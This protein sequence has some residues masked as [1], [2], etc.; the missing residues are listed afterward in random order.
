MRK[1]WVYKITSP[2]GRVY[3]GSTVNLKVRMSAYKNLKCIEQPKLYRSLVKHG[4]EKHTV[5]IICECTSLNRLEKESFFGHLYNVLSNDNLN[6]CLPK[7]NENP[8]CYNEKE[9]Q[10]RKVFMIGR[11]IAKGTKK[12]KSYT[13]NLKNKMAGTVFPVEYSKLAYEK[14]SKKVINIETGEIYNSINQAALHTGKCKS[15]LSQ[16]LNGIGKNTS[17]FI[18]LSDFIIP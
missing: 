3:I 15:F 16:V 13:D 7:T 8:V 10:R 12:P 18:R 11:K 9:I 4:F 17:P 14:T 1:A 6:L 5:D 2:T